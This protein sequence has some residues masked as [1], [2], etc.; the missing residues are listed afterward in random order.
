M[1]KMV[2]M[3]FV[4]VMMS[5]LVIILRSVRLKKLLYGRTIRMMTNVA[6]IQYVYNDEN[7]DC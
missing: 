2:N 3:F 5:T 4:R 1:I 7:D 6:F